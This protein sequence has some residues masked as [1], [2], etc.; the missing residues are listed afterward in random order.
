M[1]CLECRTLPRRGTR[2]TPEVATCALRW[3]VAVMLLGVPSSARGGEAATASPTQASP[4]TSDASAM[5]A[6]AE[7]Q[8]KWPTLTRPTDPYRIQFGVYYV[9]PATVEVPL[10]ITNPWN[11]RTA[12]T[13]PSGDTAGYG[14][15]WMIGVWLGRVTIELHGGVWLFGGPEVVKAAEAP[16]STKL[17]RPYGMPVVRYVFTNGTVVQPYVGAGAGLS[18]WTMTGGDAQIGPNGV[19]RKLEAA[20]TFDGMATAGAYFK[21]L[22]TNE[23]GKNGL[24]FLEVGAK[25]L[26]SLEGSAFAENQLAVVPFAGLSMLAGLGHE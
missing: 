3:L 12:G 25:A 24:L 11:A 4:P 26:Y 10:L 16:V 8:P 7:K 20:M 15:D 23:D 19:L 21:L 13:P 14:F 18:W 9:A 22:S 17:L 5:S 2:S 1:S 6:W